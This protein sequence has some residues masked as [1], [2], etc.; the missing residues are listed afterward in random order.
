MI[1]LVKLVARPGYEDIVGSG[2]TVQ[3]SDTDWT[4]VRLPFPTD[5]PKTGH[6]KV[7]YVNKEIGMSISRADAAAFMLK[8]V[9]EAR[10]LRQA[11]VISN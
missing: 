4:I 5:D 11:P 10:Y 6:V 7:G 2:Q 9:Q 3:A 1:G 8:E